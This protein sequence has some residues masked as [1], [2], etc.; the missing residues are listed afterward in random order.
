[1]IV[2]KILYQMFTDN[3]TNLFID[4]RLDFCERN[5]LLVQDGAVNAAAD[6][7]GDHIDHNFRLFQILSGFRDNLFINFIYVFF[8]VG[9]V[10]CHGIFKNPPA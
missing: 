4:V 8:R 7:F 2:E 9:V 10:L 3:L 5:R 1:M 6:Q